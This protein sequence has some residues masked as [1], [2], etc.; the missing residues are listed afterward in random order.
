MSDQHTDNSGRRRR[1]WSLN[2]LPA[3]RRRLA[4]I[5]TELDA[6]QVD[7]KRA[8]ALIY[9]LSTVAGILRDEALL[10]L[11]RRVTELEERKENRP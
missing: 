5:I 9:G 2:T 6:D 8:R 7:E 1:G 10:D 11:E 4:C 3:V